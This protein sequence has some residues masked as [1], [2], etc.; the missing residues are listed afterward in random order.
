MDYSAFERRGGNRF[1][2]ALAAVLLAASMSVCLLASCGDDRSEEGNP[3]TASDA[4]DGN[5][6]PLSGDPLAQECDDSDGAKYEK[7]VIY[8]YPQYE[9]D[10]SVSLSISG[11][12][13]CSY[14][15]FSCESDEAGIA[16]GTWD[17][18]ACPDGTLV[19]AGTGREYGYLFWDGDVDGDFDLSH[20]FCVA[21][22]DTA[23][24]LEDALARLG[25]T[26]KE[27]ADFVTYWLPRMQ[28]NPYNL[29]S[30]Q[31]KAYVDVA[32]L[33]VD[34][35]PDTVIRVFMVWQPLDAPVEVVP[36]TLDAPERT[37]FTVVEW[38]GTELPAL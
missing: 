14:P 3:S 18:R 1:A 11:S 34:P 33:S 21:G 37:G 24:F 22:A 28:D 35:Q 31:G 16:G 36:Q 20:G 13:S 26:D 29:V 23:A 7:P 9:T 8:L 2:P 12:V 32:R 30:F 25:L 4:Q 17:V 27:A 10:A 15:A 6:E 5:F 38:G 19:D